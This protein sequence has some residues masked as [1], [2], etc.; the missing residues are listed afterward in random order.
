MAR[1]SLS[2]LGPIEVSLDGRRVTGFE[3]DK[4]R[5]LLI[6][7][8]VEAACAHARGA[9]AGLLWPDLPESHGSPQ[10]KPGAHH[11]PPGHRGPYR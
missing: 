8:V 4:V 9:L 10:P 2:L 3:Y 11:P 1:L 6:Y 5:A 7:L